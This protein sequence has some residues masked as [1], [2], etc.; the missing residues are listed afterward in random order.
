M[1]FHATHL[2]T[3]PGSGH[4]AAPQE[5]VADYTVWLRGRFIACPGIRQ[6][7]W[8]AGR[9]VGQGHLQFRIAGP[10]AKELEAACM[11]TF[12]PSPVAAKPQS[13]KR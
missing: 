2:D 6:Y 3:T 5:P 1:Q 7:V 4:W 8:L 13:R 11:A 12:K 9:L 10:N